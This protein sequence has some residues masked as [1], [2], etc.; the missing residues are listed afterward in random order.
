MNCRECKEQVLELIERETLDPDG[1]HELLERCPECRRV[2]YDLK[3]VLAAMELPL[4]EPSAF[5][6]AAIL[7]AAAA[8]R[9]EPLATRA[10]WY[11]SPQWA[12][13][14]VALLAVSVG[15][16][17]IPS[18]ERLEEQEEEMASLSDLG[19]SEGAGVPEPT[20]LAEAQRDEEAEPVEPVAA[21]PR[22]AKS[23][24]PRAVA[25]RRAKRKAA[26]REEEPLGRSAEAV[27]AEPATRDMAAGAAAA[28]SPRE[29]DADEMLE[30]KKERRE[31]SA[32][33]TRKLR[34]L[35]S[36]RD[37][38]EEIEVDPE[39]AL[40]IGRCY[41]SVGDWVQARSWLQRAAANPET[42]P[43]AQRA[44]EQLPAE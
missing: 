3:A 13:A 26:V 7:R 44:L 16:W 39:E 27:L 28:S 36:R 37:L 11:R 9:P 8:H 32:A 29:A 23:A 43:R 2:F 17:S 10:P 12:V 5:V 34:R 19:R 15:V 35:E 1:V 22:A 4:E 24:A 33:C 6:E 21:R 42:R 31:P 30:S 38:D 41:Q 14:A 18:G 40:A 20:A 25:S